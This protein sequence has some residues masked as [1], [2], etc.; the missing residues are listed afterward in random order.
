MKE[1]RPYFC[2]K[3]RFYSGKV[4]VPNKFPFIF[5]CENGIIFI[6]KREEKQ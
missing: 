4:I 3:L 6:N 5:K 2:E 1:K